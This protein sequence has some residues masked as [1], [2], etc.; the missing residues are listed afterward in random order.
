MVS[1]KWT[2]NCTKPCGHI[3]FK[4]LPE[5]VGLF[6]FRIHGPWLSRACVVLE[7]MTLRRARLSDASSIAALSL[8]VWIGT[9]LKE[10]VNGFFADFVLSE[11]TKAMSEHLL[12]DPTQ[13]IIVSQNADGIDGVMRL[14]MR[15]QTE[16][17]N[18]PEIAT[19]YVQPRHHGK[20][21][22]KALLAAACAQCRR[23]GAPE[24]W[25]TTN[26]QNDPAIAFYAA[27]GFVKIGET[28][29]RIGDTGYLN[30]IYRLVLDRL[31]SSS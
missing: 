28:E 6:R 7:G 8:E 11:F 1:P 9:Y 12:R 16:G 10:G 22:G 18:G 30:N 31:P 15:R 14:D 27:Q 29:F 2:A 21:I 4:A 20:G 17:C 19:L 23:I 13:H 3:V 26:A 5:T 24:L 25:L